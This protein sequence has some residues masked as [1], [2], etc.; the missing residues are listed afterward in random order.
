MWSGSTPASR[1]QLQVSIAVLPAPMTVNPDAG[2]SRSTS[3][4]GGITCTPGSI[5]YLGV[6]REG[7][8]DST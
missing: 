3:A 5:S 6:C 8:D 1:S 7:I 4:F 2:S